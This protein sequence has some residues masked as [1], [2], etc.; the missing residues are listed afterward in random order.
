M[1]FWKVVVVEMGSSLNGWCDHGS[2]LWRDGSW[3]AGDVGEAGYEECAAADGGRS[4]PEE[5]IHWACSSSVSVLQ[6]GWVANME[7][8]E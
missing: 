2:P 1:R 6:E 3:Y 5:M 7:R 8:A 4:L